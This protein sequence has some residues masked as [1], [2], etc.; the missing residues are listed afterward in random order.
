MLEFMLQE[1]GWVSYKS[2]F[3]Q[4]LLLTIT[5]DS[6]AYVKDTQSFIPVL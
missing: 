2:G 4:V 6:V 3:L 5:R 1:M